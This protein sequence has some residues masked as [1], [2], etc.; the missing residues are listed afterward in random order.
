M[1]I[2]GSPAHYAGRI[3]AKMIVHGA[4]AAIAD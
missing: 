3:C 1:T 2:R 4:G